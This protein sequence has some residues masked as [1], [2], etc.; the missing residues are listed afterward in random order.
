MVIMLADFLSNAANNVLL[1]QRADFKGE[2]RNKK[3]ES[4]DVLPQ[5]SDTSRGEAPPETVATL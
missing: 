3:C 1:S 5:R 2:Q 4:A